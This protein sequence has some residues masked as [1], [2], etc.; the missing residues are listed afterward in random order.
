MEKYLTIK[1]ISKIWEIGER[2]INAL[3]QEG[4]IEGAQKFG[5]SWAIPSDA[6]KPDDMRI[7]SGKYIKS[8]K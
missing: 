7:K 1:E 8:R 4:R 3:C 2:R 6:K 5:N